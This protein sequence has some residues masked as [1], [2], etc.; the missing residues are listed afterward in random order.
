MSQ[1]LYPTPGFR[2]GATCEPEAAVG[3]TEARAGLSGA[4]SHDQVRGFV[5]MEGLQVQCDAGHLWVTI[6]NDPV[7]HVLHPCQCLLLATGGKVVIGG[8][9]SFSIRPV[10]QLSGITCA[11]L[12]TSTVLP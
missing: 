6:E 7:D 4:V 9:G 8:K 12:A 2:P 11:G 3:S 1:L 5:Q 10:D